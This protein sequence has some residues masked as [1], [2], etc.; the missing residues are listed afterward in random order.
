MKLASLLVILVAVGVP[1][2]AQSPLPWSEEEATA[3]ARH[4]P[5]PPPVPRDS[6]NR[7]AGTPAGAVLGEHL[8]NEPRLSA[9]G[10]MSCATCHVAGRDWGDGRVTA[11][12]QS[13]PH[14][15]TLSLWNVGY[16]HWF[17]WDGAGDSLWAQ[18]IRPILEP[19][20]MGSDAA[21]VAAL[22][23]E[24]ATL[25]C[26]YRR[27]FGEMPGADDEKLLVDVAKALATFQATL[28]SPRTAFDAFRDGLLS[29]QRDAATR[30]P[31][32]AQRGLK[33]FLKSNC[34]A[35][36]FGPRFTNGEFGDVGIPFFIRPG[37]VDP[38]RLDG[39]SRLASSA[40]NL[41]GRHND[42]ALAAN[43]LRTRHVQR[44]HSN[45]GEFRVPSLRQAGEGPFMHN[46]HIATLEGVVKHYS[47][48][49][50]DRLHSDA[51]PLVR[52][53]ALS[54]EQS[55]DLVAFLR[56]LS[57]DPPPRPPPPPLCP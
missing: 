33:I 1:A 11:M 34:G 40:F 42:D 12:V 50:P 3:I 54:P 49:D 44:L 41:L 23:R 47:E 5:W 45:F 46:G 22:L 14:R 53:L 26:G 38:G 29:G 4:G 35:C 32:A 51:R 16:G 19:R 43:A 30:Y 31:M 6:S 27:A 13:P 7:I 17:G 2:V 56:S 20:E 18:S 25:A 15:R 48:V 10:A 24:D 52:P 28:V 8:F 39:L 57:A 21:R 36:H 37:E 9:D 55:T